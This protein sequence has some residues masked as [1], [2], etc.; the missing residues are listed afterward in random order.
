MEIVER[1]AQRASFRSAMVIG[2]SVV[3]LAA[4]SA[5]SPRQV[6][7]LSTPEGPGSVFGAPHL[8]AGFTKTFTSR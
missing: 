8:P 6:T 2:A 5:T 7:R 1:L 4:V 3:V